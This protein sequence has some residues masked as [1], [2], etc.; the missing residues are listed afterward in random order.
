ME[1]YQLRY[2]AY[3]AKYENITM[4]AQEL[5]V[6]QPSISKAIQSLERELKT[7]LLRKNGRSCVLTHDG[8]LL[9]ERV[10]PLLEEIEQLPLEFRNR[11]KKKLIRLNVLT[12]GLLVPELI[13]EFREE[14]PDVFFQVLDRREATKWDV[15][16]R[17]TLP[18]YVFSNA[19]KLMEEPLCLA[20]HKDSWLRNVEKVR[21]SDIRNEKFV[22][23]RSGGSIRTISDAIFE[24]EGIIPDIAFECDT[25]NILRRMV[26]EGLGIAIWPRYSW[27]D[28]L[29]SETDFENVCYRPIDNNEFKRSLYLI[30]QKDLKM[31]E[32]LTEFCKYTEKY[33]N[34]IKEE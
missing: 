4:A 22:M 24:K 25:V 18:Q 20:F 6:S 31:T 9:Q 19:V 1:I 8:Y 7:E 2:F 16:I 17:S 30:L 3:A 12:G 14:N 27:R 13:R 11:Q 23:L 29:R 32:E 5:N 26:Q 10:V 34:N 28:H 33:F 21:L 15:C